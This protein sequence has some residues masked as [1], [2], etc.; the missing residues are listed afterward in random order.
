MVIWQVNLLHKRNAVL[1]S[2]AIYGIIVLAKIEQLSVIVAKPIVITI[3]AIGV[4]IVALLCHYFSWVPILSHS[5]TTHSSELSKRTENSSVSDTIQTAERK[6]VN[7]D[8]KLQ[9]QEL[10]S[11][12]ADQIKLRTVLQQIVAHSHKDLFIAPTVK[13]NIALKLQQQSWRAALHSIA[14]VYNLVIQEGDQYIF[15]TTQD[16]IAAEHLKAQHRQREQQKLQ[17]LHRIMIPVQHAKASYI[18]QFIK[19]HRL[20]LLAKEGAID[21]D[22]GGN[23]IWLVATASQLLALRKLIKQLDHPLLQVQVK[24]R[25]VSIEKTTA[26]QM[27]I[28]IRPMTESQS[29]HA[30]SSAVSSLSS[31]VSQ[32]ASGA[33]WTWPVPWLHLASNTHLELNLA[34]LEQQGRARIVASPQVITIDH[35]AAVIASGEEIPYQHLG[36]N[37][38]TL[39]HFKKA[40]L[41]LKVTPDITADHKIRL[42]LQINEDRPSS[43]QIQGIPAIATRT[44]HSQV[45]LANQSTVVIGGID[46]QEQSG[47]VTAIPLWSR[48]PFI[49]HLFKQ[50]QRQ[51]NHSEL[52]LLVSAI[53]LE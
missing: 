31:T 4:T 13:A 45:L 41:A 22:E 18:A 30:N 35:H 43:R 27:G 39:V 24:V 25:V 2:L 1:E 44:I 9:Q 48:I 3:I 28:A 32:V 8:A 7:T 40:V 14:S 37:G 20:K 33:H 34:A 26:K 10:I 11:I 51:H 21:I 53:I 50:H 47:F 49:G 36:G 19:R 38:A 29:G 23:A 6:S 52:L 46:E 16:Q 5:D 12:A 42:D 15:I 17:P